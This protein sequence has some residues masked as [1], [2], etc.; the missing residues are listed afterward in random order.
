MF[1][2][3]GLLLFAA[4]GALVGFMAGLVGIGG[5]L[6][7]VPVLLG[8]F[9]DAGLPLSAALPLATGTSLAAIVSTTALSAHASH[10]NGSFDPRLLRRFAIPVTIGA[11]SGPFIARGLPQAMIQCA[12]A[13]LFVFVAIAL[14]RSAMRK[15]E[16]EADARWFRALPACIQTHV[17][18]IA[19]WLVGA[20]A[21]VAGAGGNTLMV[22]VIARLTG[23]PFKTAIGVSAGLGVPLALAGAISHGFHEIPEARHLLDAP[24]L[25]SIHVSAFIG[26]A[27]GSACTVRLGAMVARRMNTCW[28]QRVFALLLS[29]TAARLVHALGGDGGATAAPATDAADQLLALAV[30]VGA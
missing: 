10:R 3:D 26:L 6:I 30:Y 5:G 14:V 29:L 2:L 17:V 19:T 12:I 23:V 13:S 28:L 21:G 1:A 27:L 4:T 20:V 16:P 8:L 15:D 22:P 18:R 7:M 9:I 11:L 25:G 24:L